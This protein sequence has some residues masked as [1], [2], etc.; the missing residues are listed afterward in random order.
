M[1]VARDADDVPYAGPFYFSLKNDDKI[2]KQWKLD[3]CSG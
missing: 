2:L 1:V 3:P